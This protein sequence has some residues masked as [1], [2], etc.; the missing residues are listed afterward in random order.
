MSVLA[1]LLTATPGFP[2]NQTPLN[3]VGPQASHIERTFFFIFWITAVVYVLVLLFLFYAVWRRR[4]PGAVFPPPQVTTPA[5]DS[6]AVKAVASAMA[7]TILLLF[8]MLVSSFFTSRATAALTSKDPVTINITGHQWWWEI[9]YPNSEADKTVTTAN[10][11][12]LPTGVPILIEST[13]SDVIHSFWAPNI[14]GKRDLLPG[15]VTDIWMQ[16]DKPGR[17]RGQCAEF[18]GE[19]HAHMSFYIVGESRADYQ[20]WLDSQ[21]LSAT[22]PGD[23][24]TAHGREVFLTHSCVMCHTIRGTTA[25]ARVG[26]D[27]THVASRATIAAGSL[28]NNPGNLGGW[29]TNAQ[30]IKPG[31]RMPPNPMPSQDLNDLLAYLE[32]LR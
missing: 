3:P 24:K 2:G 29:I 13:S 22:E 17:W 23:P 7:V 4:V 26:P 27:L 12:H 1:F 11:I 6:F 15:Y 16:V 8:A 20:K 32:T 31:V 25:G 28:P 21:V 18:C 14:H 9:N 5:S 30:T 10:E 19:Q